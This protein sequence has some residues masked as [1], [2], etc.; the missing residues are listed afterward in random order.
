LIVSFCPLSYASEYDTVN[1]KAYELSEVDTP[2][3]VI[4]AS[5][6]GW[7]K[8]LKIYEGYVKVRF[9]VTKEGQTRDIKIVQSIPNGLYNQVVVEAVQK[10][11]YKPAKKDG[12]PVGCIV[13]LPVDFEIEGFVTTVD[14]YKGI[15]KGKALINSGEY[16]K[17]IE[18]LSEAIKI[19]DTCSDPNEYIEFG[20]RNFGKYT[21]LFEE[22]NK[23]I[24]NDPN[25]MD[26]YFF[27]GVAFQK[28]DK[29]IESIADYTKVIELDKVYVES[30]LNRAV[31]YNKLKDTVHMCLDL[32]K[33]CEL[34]VCKGLD[35]AK[36]AGRCSDGGDITN[37]KN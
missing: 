11:R 12:N 3:K 21:K 9:V 23:A 14:A 26:A 30:Y 20:K 27:R 10:Y 25:R 17:A 13:S 35:L 15:E 19:Y 5:P 4:K 28:S 8:G 36:K 22:V 34:G 18:T 33:A 32:K 2:P 31:C 1:E 29:Y 24:M 6:P 16:D 37:Y 7:P